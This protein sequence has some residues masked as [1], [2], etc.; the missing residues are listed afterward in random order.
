MRRNSERPLGF[1]HQQL[2]NDVVFFCPRCVIFPVVLRVKCHIVV[3][4]DPRLV[5]K[6]YML[7][8]QACAQAIDYL[9]RRLFSF[10]QGARGIFCGF[11]QFQR[12]ELEFISDYFTRSRFLDFGIPGDF[13]D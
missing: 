7:Y 12:A 9:L 8:W 1:R 2:V 5:T 3:A 13:A 4:L 6:P 10:R 11:R